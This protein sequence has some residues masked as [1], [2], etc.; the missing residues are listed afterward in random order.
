V[1]LVLFKIEK[2][3]IQKTPEAREMAN[4]QLTEMGP[5]SFHEKIQLAVFI[6]CLLLWA[7]GSIHGIHA[8]TVAITGTAVL[9]LAG[10]LTWDD[11]L[12]E[13][14]GWDSFF[15]IAALM[16]LADLIT[17]G[18]VLDW[19]A[20]AISPY[21]SNLPWL[22]ALIVVALIYLYSEYFFA[23]MT[24]HISAL[25][26]PMLLVLITA[27]APPMLSALVLAMLSSVCGGLTNYAGGHMPI[28]FG[29]GYVDQGAWWKNGF[30][31]SLINV[32][33]FLGVGAMWW[34]IIGMY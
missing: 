3:T 31:C 33:T 5:L 11:C 9:L 7:T 19:F 26:P 23:S 17:Q 34:K 8:T 32:A 15:W 10:V 14:T 4:K 30:I 29:M 12:S 1:P 2:P 28:W 22:P 27:G 20:Q 25:Y 16:Q 24:A 13:K 21:V 18:G 6:G